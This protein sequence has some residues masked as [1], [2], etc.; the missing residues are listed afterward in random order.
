MSDRAKWT[1]TRTECEK[2]CDGS[3]EC[4]ECEDGALTYRAEPAPRFRCV[5][6][7]EDL[8]TRRRDRTLIDKMR[9][10]GCDRIWKRVAEHERPPVW[11]SPE[12][13]GQEP[14]PQPFPEPAPPTPHLKCVCGRYL[15]TRSSDDKPWHVI[16]CVGTYGCWREWC[17][18]DSC[19]GD[20]YV[21]LG[22]STGGQMPWNPV[23][24]ERN[25]E[26]LLTTQEPKPTIREK[27]LA[28][29]PLKLRG[30]RCDHCSGTGHD[31]ALGGACRRCG[32][33][34]EIL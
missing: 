22:R 11:S 31:D 17:L 24:L 1:C 7:T 29:K 19:D 15:D 10:P 26:A 6:G 13:V 2:W 8:I 18:S 9:C 34:G 30:V 32:G 25:A 28:R 27:R 3:P 23:R 20:G 4:V 14:K 5:C 12:R 16:R 21:W 33:T